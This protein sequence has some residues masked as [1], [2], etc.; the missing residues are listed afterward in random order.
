MPRPPRRTAGARRGEKKDLVAASKAVR[1]DSPAPSAVIPSSPPV[2][3][4]TRGASI[5][6][7][8]AALSRTPTSDLET[9]PS[10]LPLTNDS[11]DIDIPESSGVAACVS[12]NTIARANEAAS[13]IARNAVSNIQVQKT[14]SPNAIIRVADV[15][16]A[17][18]PSPIETRG[19]KRDSKTAFEEDFAASLIAA[20]GDDEDA[21][22]PDT[23]TRTASGP[24]K[25][26]QSFER[27]SDDDR[28]HPVLNLTG[29]VTADNGKRA[30]NPDDT[31]D[32]NYSSSPERSPAP[33][34]FGLLKPLEIHSDSDADTESEDEEERDENQMDHAEEP[35]APAP[36][37]PRRRRAVIATAATENPQQADAKHPT[38]K[39]LQSLLPK[40]RNKPTSTKSK[41]SK[42]KAKSK[43]KTQPK[44]Q[45][46]A[47]PR[48]ALG[49][50]TQDILDEDEL[51][52][53]D[54]PPR[55]LFGAGM[56]IMSDDELGREIYVDSSARSSSV[57]A[58]PTP[59]SPPPRRTRGG[60]GKGRAASA[61]PEVALGLQ[62]RR[63]TY[64]KPRR[65]DSEVSNKENDTPAGRSSG[66]LM[67]A[68]SKLAVAAD[69]DLNKKEKK[70]VALIRRKFRE[71]DQ[72]DLCFEDVA[73]SSD[74]VVAGAR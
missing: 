51:Q 10:T 45:A 42:A 6:R 55:P 28:E 37:R 41:A 4:N 33:R 34:L 64:G 21:A 25:K 24:R 31:I 60:K 27:F 59:P 29:K 2:L 5:A 72:W 44:E 54:A 16:S 26:R 32:F 1:V 20:E 36:S 17:C 68:S 11:N 43:P 58:P 67:A 69:V 65:Q 48:R 15:L 40:R 19:K 38:T 30:A 71:V 22:L 18:T 70:E 56:D 57:G 63:R 12:E 61:E 46:A 62:P 66:R 74:G 14:P 9:I 53:I 3:R 49:D 23:P 13:T 52:A 35:E 73:P 8:A 47:K 39:S 50:V 7:A